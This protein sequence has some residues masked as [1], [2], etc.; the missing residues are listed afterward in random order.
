MAG[1]RSRRRIWD[2]EGET[3][4]H[5][6]LMRQARAT[7]R[8]QDVAAIRQTVSICLVEFTD[9]CC[10]MLKAS[11]YSAKTYRLTSLLARMSGCSVS[12]FRSHIPLWKRHGSPESRS[13]Y[14]EWLSSSACLRSRPP[15]VWKSCSRP[16]PSAW[17]RFPVQSIV[18]DGE[19][20]IRNRCRSRQSVSKQSTARQYISTDY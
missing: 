4:C 18:R 3:A 15:P 16:P 17:W 1:S 2:A 19:E 10:H 5:M 8:T 6:A 13:V 9:W 14:Q 20:P 7:R 11:R 12:L